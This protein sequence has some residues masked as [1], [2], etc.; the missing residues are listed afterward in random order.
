MAD[1][2]KD[3]HELIVED[4][5]SPRVHQPRYKKRKITISE[6][7]TIISISVVAISGYTALGYQVKAHADDIKELQESKD[8]SA[9]KTE[10]HR[11]RPETDPRETGP[12]PT[13]GI[14]NSNHA[15]YL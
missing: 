5:D 6:W 11:C 2:F 9:E 8:T 12:D 3:E 15:P 7:I 4:V 13:A 14:L 10:Q 1:L